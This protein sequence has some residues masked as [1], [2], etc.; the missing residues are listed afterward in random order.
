MLLNEDTERNLRTSEE[1]HE[2]FIVEE[3]D[4]PRQLYKLYAHIHLVYNNNR[5]KM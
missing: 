2:A 5:T 4:K 3:G 1:K